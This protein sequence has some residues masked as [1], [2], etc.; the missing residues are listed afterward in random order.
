MLTRRAFTVMFG[1]GLMSTPSAVASD[2]DR[3]E[4]E[5]MKTD[6]DWKKELTQEQYAVLREHGTERAGTSPLDKN[7]APGEYR[8]AACGLPLF[9]SETKYDSGSGW[10][11]FWAPLDEAVGTSTDF[12]LIYPRTEV[13]C[14][15]C[16]GHLGHVFQDGP[17]PT[18]QR[19]CMNG[20]ALDFVPKEE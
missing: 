12:K 13:H 8:C 9:S 17:E 3:Q 1:A 6:Q 2:T 20:V 15:R 14:R 7:Y 11:S 18:G 10:P 4:F 16:G 19:Y 5:I